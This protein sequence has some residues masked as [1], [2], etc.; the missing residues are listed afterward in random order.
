LHNASPIEV[1]L[2][3][4]DL[5]IEQ[6][7]IATNHTCMG[8]YSDLDAALKAMESSFHVRLIATYSPDLV[9]APANEVATRWLETA[10]A[11]F[12]QFP[13]KQDDT[14][15]GVLL[16]QGDHGS[17]TVREAMQRLSEEQIVSA[18][19][20]IA[21][22]IPLLRGNHYRLVIRGNHIDGLV[23]QSDL[24]KL[25]VRILVFALLT[26]LE[27][28]MAN[29]ITMRW[30][31]DEWLTELNAGRQSHI[32]EK[33]STLRD[34][35]INPRKIELTDFCDKRDLCR[36]LIHGSKNKFTKELDALR[37][38]RDQIAHAATFVDGSDGKT[39]VVAFVDKFQNTKHWIDELTKLG[40][41]YTKW[42][43]T[44]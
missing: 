13:V 28:V 41:S 5:E 18:D 12:D 26:H 44:P 19:M 35:K 30:Q 22:L 24:L 16:R 27:Q 11:D 7:I 31:D 37:D 10:N 39:G 38:L 25:P 15:V 21:D 17:K 34:R 43:D 20:P 1:A 2:F 29:V 32:T 6:T 40:S 33:E 8:I 3:Y 4:A 9:Y 36:Q 42:D 14:T 23:T